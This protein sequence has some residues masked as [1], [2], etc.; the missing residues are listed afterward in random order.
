MACFVALLSIPLK[1]LIE[2]W[3]FHLAMERF[4]FFSFSPHPQASIHRHASLFFPSHL[5]LILI[6]NNFIISLGFFSSFYHFSSCYQHL[7]IILTFAASTMPRSLCDDATI[8][9]RRMIFHLF[10]FE[11]YYTNISFCC[12]FFLKFIYIFMYTSEMFFSPPFN[13]VLPSLGCVFCHV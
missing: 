6:K 5:N 10:S 11:F 7:K 4:S 8:H 3:K 12:Y 1:F 13:G 9:I 2:L